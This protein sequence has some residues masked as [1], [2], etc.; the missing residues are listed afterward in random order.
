MK[1]SHLCINLKEKGQTSGHSC[2]SPLSPSLAWSKRSWRLKEG[3]EPPLGVCCHWVITPFSWQK[4]P[5]AGRE[6]GGRQAAC[7]ACLRRTQART[8]RTAPKI[9]S[10]FLWGHPQRRCRCKVK[11]LPTLVQEH[12][13][14]SKREG[15]HEKQPRP[16]RPEQHCKALGVTLSW[17]M[18]WKCKRSWKCPI[19]RLDSMSF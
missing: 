18:L 10:E 9:N 5:I 19:K 8:T 17:K 7:T 14:N 12:G 16:T 11:S 6:P 4:I 15:K 1:Y 13:N 2:R 3:R